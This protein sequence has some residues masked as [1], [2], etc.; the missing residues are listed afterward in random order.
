VIRNPLDLNIFRPRDKRRARR[1]LGIPGHAPVV[2]AAADD[3]ADP[4]KGADMLK[5]SLLTLPGGP[6]TLVTMGKN[7]PEM[8][9]N[10][11]HHLHMGF[12]ADEE[13]KADLYS[14]ADAFVHPAAQDNL[15]NTIAEALACGTPVVGF[16]RGGVPEMVSGRDC[17]ALSSE[18][19][20]AGLGMA[21]AKLFDR[22]L[23]Q[24]SRTARLAAV[25]LFE[26]SRQA[27]T[28]LRLLGMD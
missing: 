26:P 11:L 10:S 4:R 24:A 19:T 12:V 8:G 16:A 23:V 27:F 20:P 22:D 1:V 13:K 6:V 25:E 15:P 14:A 28:Y 9:S 3:F 18:R 17:G 5:S 21:L 7:A 2:L